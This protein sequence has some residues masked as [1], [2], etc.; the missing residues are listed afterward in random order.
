MET[1]FKQDNQALGMKKR[2]KKRFESQQMLT[3]LNAL[4]HNVLV[5]ASA[6]VDDGT[7]IPEK[8]R[9]CAIATGCVDHYWRTL[10]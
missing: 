2:N 4:A 10:L 9:L 1:S 3:Q 8:D 5:W 6:M 7:T